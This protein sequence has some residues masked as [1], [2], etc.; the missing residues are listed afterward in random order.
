MALWFENNEAKCAACWVRGTAD[1]PLHA[2]NYR[3]LRIECVECMKTRMYR[4]RLGLEKIAM[5]KC[6]CSLPMCVHEL[7][8]VALNDR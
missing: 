1:K 6:D 2:V 5:R 4:Y 8:Q 7:A 3:P